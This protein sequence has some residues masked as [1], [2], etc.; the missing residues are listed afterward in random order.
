ME[1][2]TTADARKLH[3]N[4]K[5]LETTCVTCGR[6]FRFGEEVACCCTCDQFQHIS[7][8]E[9]N[10][11]PHPAP[12]PAPEVSPLAAPEP[13]PDPAPEAP[14]PVPLNPDERICPTC[15][16]TIKSAAL[17]C[18]FCNTV[19]DERMKAADIPEALAKTAA[20]NARSALICGL[21]GLVVCAPVFASMAIS[22]GNSAIEVLDRYPLYDGPRGRARAGVV[23][24]WIGWILFVGGFLV[25]I[26]NAR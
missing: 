16:E 26:S 14:A 17:R 7:C 15:K 6:S 25:R 4:R 12:P 21:I 19:L 3:A 5:A 18:R 24:G 20:S 10:T 11:C 22:S 13:A 9:G 1:N 8:W 23:L 2:I